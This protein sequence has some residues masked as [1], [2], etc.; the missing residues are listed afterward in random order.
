M[1]GV[2]LADDMGLGK[3]FQVFAFLY[4]LRLHEATDDRPILVVA[5]AKLLQEWQEQIG[6]HLP[7][8]ALGRPVLG[9]DRGLREIAVERGQETELGRETLD[10]ERLRQ[11]DR[12]LTTYETLRD[13]QFSFARV[14]F[15]VAVFDE[16][17]KIKSGASML[18]HA[19]KAQQ[20]DFVI[21][22]TGTPI[23]N[24]TMDL[25]TLLDVAWPGFLGVSGKDFVAEY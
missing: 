24:S 6:I 7:P 13:H 23:E 10:V 1:P 21:L 17:Q 19:A 18:N 2:L 20:P 15:R 16:A 14:R 22:M 8:G 12:V 25:W 9:Y 5:P 3:T 4:W 11:A